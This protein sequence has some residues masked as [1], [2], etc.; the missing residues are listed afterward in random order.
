MPAL[1]TSR[2]TD[3]F[4]GLD[5]LLQVAD[6]SKNRSQR[7]QESRKTYFMFDTKNYKGYNLI[8]YY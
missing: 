2:L 6:S 7:S 3:L 5:H 1:T 4:E 8:P